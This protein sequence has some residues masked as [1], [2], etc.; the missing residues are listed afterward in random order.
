[1]NADLYSGAAYR[2]MGIRTDQF[3]PIFALSRVSG[4]RTRWSSAATIA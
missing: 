1:M 2:A 4:P 3:T